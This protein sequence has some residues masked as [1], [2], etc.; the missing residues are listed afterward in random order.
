MNWIE[1][2]ITIIR[3]LLVVGGAWVGYKA[4]KHY[5]RGQYQQAIYGMLL[6]IFIMICI[7]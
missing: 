1:W 5:S 2:T 7:K 4:N 3:L 6:V